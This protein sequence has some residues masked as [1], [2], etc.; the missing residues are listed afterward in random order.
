MKTIASIVMTGLTT[1]TLACG[2]NGGSNSSNT[3]ANDAGRNGDAGGGEQREL[4]GCLL[5]GGDAGSYVLQ[6]GSVGD[7][8]PSSGSAGA[9]A[10]AAGT[11]V[12]GATYRVIARN[13]QD[14]ESHLNK[15]VAVNGS[16][17]GGNGGS[18]GTAGGSGSSSGSSRLP[19]DSSE[20][21][22]VRVESV[23]QVADQCPTGASRR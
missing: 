11:W 18:V 4:T 6:L 1:L 5:A 15:L 12:P 13:G 21:G 16:V 20:L 9:P 7:A 3:A 8:A 2:G 17:E 22:T 23:R 14:L 10:G 19:S